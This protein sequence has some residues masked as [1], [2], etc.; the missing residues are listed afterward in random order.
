M[1][2]E[3]QAYAK[4][5]QESFENSLAQKKRDQVEAVAMARAER[6]AKSVQQLDL[7]FARAL[8][9]ADDDGRDMD[10]LG[11]R[12]G[13]FVLGRTRIEEVLVSSSPAFL[14]NATIQPC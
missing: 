7:E 9:K 14:V 8:Q 3:N 5:L 6:H 2:T 12:G 11:K 10:K 13:E 4:A 1:E